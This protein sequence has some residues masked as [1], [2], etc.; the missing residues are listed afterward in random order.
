MI[1]KI[2][3]SVYILAYNEEAKIEVTL[4]SVSWADEI[5]VIDSYSTDRT[6]EISEQMGAKV[7]QIKFNGFGELRMAGI[8][9]TSHEWIFSIDSDERGGPRSLGKKL[10][11]LSIMKIQRYLLCTKKKYFYGKK[12]TI[13]WLVPKL[14]GSLNCSEEEK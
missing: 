3:L 9:N 13:L 11:Q 1:N 12:N 10:Y 8:K 14:A 7:V 2:P 4:Q 5:I 6:V